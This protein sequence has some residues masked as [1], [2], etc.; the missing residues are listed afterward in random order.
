MPGGNGT[1]EELPSTNSEYPEG[2]RE[3]G[4]PGGSGG[5]R[6]GRM[7]DLHPT[8]GQSWLDA[9]HVCIP[10]PRDGR[11]FTGLAYLATA[12]NLMSLIILSFRHSR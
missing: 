9:L 5:G 8:H 7:Y 11:P 6:E 10:T 1:R 2:G 4:K 12:P 3:G